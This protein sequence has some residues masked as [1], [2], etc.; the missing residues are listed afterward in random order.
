MAVTLLRGMAP[1]SA[2]LRTPFCAYPIVCVYSHIS[3]FWCQ[4]I[5]GL[6]ASCNEGAPYV[7]GYPDAWREARR[8]KTV[9]NCDLARPSQRS[10][11]PNFY[12]AGAPLAACA[13]G[14]PWPTP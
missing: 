2:P 13:L 1:R 3:L 8:Y 14:H 11:I 5:S 6:Q 4:R 9:P 7:C 10:P 12:M